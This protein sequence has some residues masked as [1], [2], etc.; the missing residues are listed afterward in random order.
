M[1]VEKRTERKI[2]F[3]VIAILVLMSTVVIFT[4]YYKGLILKNELLFNIISALSTSGLATYFSFIG[5]FKIDN[6]L[7]KRLPWSNSI[8]KRII[9]EYIFI[10]AYSLSVMAIIVFCLNLIFDIHEETNFFILLKPTFI[11]VVIITTSII[12]TGFVKGWETAQLNIQKL[13]KKTANAR[14]EALKAN[15]KP[16]SQKML[17][18]V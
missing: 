14:F 5:N 9:L 12:F 10:I 16:P 13:E 6:I 18:K 2:T 3:S 1:D 17:F 4:S 11:I 7:E 15:I 8:L